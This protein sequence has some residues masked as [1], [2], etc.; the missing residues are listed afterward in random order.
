MAIL[1]NAFAFQ[2]YALGEGFF[3]GFSD[4][5]QP[6]N[7]FDRLMRFIPKYLLEILEISE[8]DIH[9]SEVCDRSIHFSEIIKNKLL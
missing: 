8:M 2:L 3:E 7:L 1:A 9:I 4:F 6:F 5:C